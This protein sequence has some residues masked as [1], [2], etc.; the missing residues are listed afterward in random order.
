MKRAKIWIGLTSAVLIGGQAVGTSAIAKAPDGAVQQT[1]RP[2]TAGLMM[3]A[4]GGEGG[5]AGGAAEG[6][7]DDE[8]LTPAVAKDLVGDLRSGGYVIYFR[9]FETGKDTPDYAE[10]TMGDCGTQR[11][12]N[13]KGAVQAIHVRNAFQKLEIPVSKVLS[14]PF[15]RAW[16]SA[17][18]AFGGHQV[19]EGLKLPPVKKFGPKEE[20]EMRAALYPLLTEKPKEGSNTIIVA[21]DD[22]LPTVG[23]PYPESQGEALIFKPDGKGGFELK[24]QVKPDVWDALLRP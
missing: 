20:Q 13:E 16:Q 14:S 22:N 9:H 2:S 17:D 8:N 21:H 7:I 23:A 3:L 1:N 11:Q 5:E 18:L 10:A 15:C 24:F 19:V 12:L 6:I 4:E